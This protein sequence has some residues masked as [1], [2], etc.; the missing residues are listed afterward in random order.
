MKCTDR[1]GQHP[2]PLFSFR[3][4]KYFR[5]SLPL[6][7]PRNPEPKRALK[8]RNNGHQDAKMVQLHISF[9]VSDSV[10]MQQLIPAL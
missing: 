5:Y 7:S 9:Y 8:L 1:N 10:D 3:W 6:I 2:E 4:Q